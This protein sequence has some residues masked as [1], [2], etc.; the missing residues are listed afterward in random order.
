MEKITSKII[1]D[2]VQ[3]SFD[4]WWKSQ[5]VFIPYFKENL[6]IVFMD[7]TANEDVNFIE[8][9]DAALSNFLNLSENNRNEI[10][11]LV[12]KNCTDFLDMVEYDECDEPLHQIKNSNEF[13]PTQPN[14]YFKTSSKR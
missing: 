9:A 13:C 8:E 10:L 2:L 12:H 6:E 4:D 3:D 14:L 1:G 5:P 7:F 11:A